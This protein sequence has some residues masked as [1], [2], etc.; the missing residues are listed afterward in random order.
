MKAADTFPKI[1]MQPKRDPVGTT[2]V[3]KY[4]EVDWVREFYA[5]ESPAISEDC[6]YLNVWQPKG[7]KKGDRL[8]V[9]FWIHGGAFSYGYGHEIEFD[10][11]AYARRGVILVSIN[12]RLGILGFLAH[13]QL[14][15][16][17]PRRVSGNYGLLDQIQALQWVRDNIAA[18]GGDPENITIYGQSAGA[19]SVRQ[20]LASPLT[21]GMPA[22]AIIQSGGGIGKA[23]RSVPSLAEYEQLGHAMF[24]GKTLA[25]MRAMS[26]DELLKTVNDY[27]A[28]RHISPMLSP[29]LDGYVITR[30]LEAS[31][32]S[33]ALP[34]IPYMWGCTLDDMGF[35]RIEMGLPEVSVFLK[36]HGYAPAYIYQFCRRMPGDMAGAYHSSELW[37][38]FG[39]LRNCWRPITDKDHELSNRMLDYWTDFMKTGNPNGGPHPLWRPYTKGHPAIMEFDVEQER[40]GR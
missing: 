7:A 20:L 18:F 35:S 23:G 37:Y 19:M 29:V 6:L 33:G 25:Q 4:G 32:E 1:A 12:Y 16:E 39:T 8:P 14:S 15:A 30:P 11:E 2:Q 13:A 31:I 36:E 9:A 28:A 10:G 21:N 5:G 38:M 24:E 34:R 3:T 22:R 17:N 27:C 26:Y 40:S